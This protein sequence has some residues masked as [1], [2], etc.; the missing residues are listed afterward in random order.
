[1]KYLFFPI[2]V[3]F[4]SYLLL[5]EWFVSVI[6]NKPF[7]FN[8]TDFFTG[9]IFSTIVAVFYLGF[10]LLLLFYVYMTEKSR[11]ENPGNNSKILLT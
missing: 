6:S 2:I 1:M 7:N 8:F 10:L 5:L 3:I 9:C 4:R 11:I